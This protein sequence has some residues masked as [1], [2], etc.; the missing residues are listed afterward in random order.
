[1][2]RPPAPRGWALALKFPAHQA[3][4]TLESI[5]VQVGRTGVLTPV[6]E[7]TPVNVGGVTVSRATL[8]NQDEIREKDLREGDRVLIQRRGGM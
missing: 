2:G 1:M 4:T 8:H 5:F 3:E 6:A 7:L